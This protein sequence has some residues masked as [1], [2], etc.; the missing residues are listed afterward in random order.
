MLTTD[1]EFTDWFKNT[2][3]EVNSSSSLRGRDG[4]PGGRTTAHSSGATLCSILATFIPRTSVFEL[5]SCIISSIASSTGLS[6]K[7]K[8]KLDNKHV[9]YLQKRNFKNYLF[10]LLFW[11]ISMHWNAK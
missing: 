8:T 2:S 6:R 9:V 5:S 10:V 1:V 7:N 11:K 3:N 4:R